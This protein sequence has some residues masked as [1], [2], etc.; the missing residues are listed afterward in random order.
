MSEE[1]VVKGARENNL[2]DIDVT[3]PKNKLVVIT[4]LSGSGKSS[5]AFDTIFA[6]GQ[7]RYVESLSSYARQFLGMVEKPDVDSI[8]GLSPA[9]S[10]DQ[11][12]TSRNP[13]STVAT[14]TEIYDYLRLLYARI[15][16]PH[17]P[18]C[19][20]QITQLTQ[21]DMVDEILRLKKETKNPSSQPSPK[22][23]GVKALVL[24]PIVSQKKGEFQHISEE[25]LKKGFARVRV[26]GVI[27]A[28]D[29]FPLL[30]KQK[31]HTIEIVVD[32]LVINEESRNRISTSVESALN[33]TNSLVSVLDSDT[34]DLYP[35]SKAFA[36]P[37]HPEAGLKELEPRVFSFNSPQGACPE[38]TGLGMRLEVDPELLMPNPRLSI[39]E[40]AIRP[41]QR[42]GADAWTMKQILATCEAHGIDARKPVG[43][44]TEA[45]K[46]VILEG[47]DKKVKVSFGRGS[48]EVKFE[49]VAKNIRRR[50]QDT[51]SENMRR[52]LEK[53][54]S[55]L[56]KLKIAEDNNTK[57]NSI[58]LGDLNPNYK[59]VKKLSSTVAAYK[60]GTK[61]YKDKFS[62]PTYIASIASA[63]GVVDDLQKLGGI[64]VQAVNSED[65]LKDVKE[66]T[67]K[68]TKAI[69][70]IKDSPKPADMSTPTDTYHKAL[71]DICIPLLGT[72]ETTLTGKTGIM[73]PED[74][75]KVKEILSGVANSASS[76]VNGSG[77]AS[78]DINQLSA[79]L[80]EAHD[81]ADKLKQAAEAILKG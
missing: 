60:E 18:I 8:T 66:L 2:K 80:R 55:G 5:L 50:W 3:I 65:V 20:K 12:T 31:K 34:D 61:S 76:F 77:S 35:F 16:V 25:Y 30:E 24:A 29:E 26:D 46:K 38:C 51:D 58:I 4:G 64:N 17:C 43:E 48:Y 13:R 71:T 79:Y 44:L 72:I 63:N 21:T 49:G 75:T 39:T 40:G 36:C 78:F 23:E 32:R 70:G 11:K 81:E 68:C 56:N 6:E 42:M 74:Q 41:L 19:D 73:T 22:G 47:S 45:E 69:T 7:R 14:V 9:I 37:D 27:Y 53:L 57:L 1:I 62:Y 33:L 15:G 10:I 52:E 28:L 59:K 54:E 67:D